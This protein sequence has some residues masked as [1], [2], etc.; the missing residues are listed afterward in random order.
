MILKTSVDT[1]LVVGYTDNGHRD[2]IDG[3]KY[4]EVCTVGGCLV[5]CIS[6]HS[7]T[8]ESRAG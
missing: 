1:K 8:S 6:E 2:L 5:F 7:D 4:E 3:E